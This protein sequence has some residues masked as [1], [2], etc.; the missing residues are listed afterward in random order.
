MLEP[1]SANKFEKIVKSNLKLTEVKKENVLLAYANA[2][3]F[4]HSISVQTAMSSPGKNLGS[5]QAK[6]YLKMKKL[7]YKIPPS[8][9]YTWLVEKLKKI[10]KGDG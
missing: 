4:A 5:K 2:K 3:M 8:I 1:F 6:R 9:R 7:Y 10:Y